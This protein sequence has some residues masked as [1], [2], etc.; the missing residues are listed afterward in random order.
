MSEQAF[1]QR[2]EPLEVA[3]KRGR[4]RKDR[5]DEPQFENWAV[6]DNPTCLKWRVLAAPASGLFFCGNKGKTDARACAVLD[7]WIVRCVGIELADKLRKVLF[8]VF[9]FFSC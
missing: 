3:E 4:K 5:K 6:C 7:D 1:R 9:L 8:D 2:H